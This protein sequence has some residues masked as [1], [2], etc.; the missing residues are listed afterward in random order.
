MPVITQIFMMSESESAKLVPLI[1]DFLDRSAEVEAQVADVIETMKDRVSRN[2]AWTI[3]AVEGDLIG[4]FYMK[5]QPG[6]YGGMVAIIE[7]L[8]V[9]PD[10]MSV[11]VMDQVDAMANMWANWNQCQSVA[12]ITRRNPIAFI[13]RLG[14]GWKLDSHI[15]KRDVWKI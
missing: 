12:F 5:K 7:Q 8:Y 3:Y 6:E 4:Y 9:H 14:S 10:Y 1:K 2:S 15:L 11:R 13:R